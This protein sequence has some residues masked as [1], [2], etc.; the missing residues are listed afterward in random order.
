M[1]VDPA[2]PAL[3]V[4]IPTFNNEPVLQKTIASWRERAAGENVEILVIEDGCRDG[5]RDFLEAQCRTRWGAR[6]LRWLH[7][8]DAHELRCTN[9]GIAAARSPLVLAWQ[10]DMFLR[11]RWLVPELLRTFDAYPDIGLLSLSRG[12]DHHPAAGPIRSWDDLVDWQRLTSTIG[13]P[14]LNWFRIQEVDGVIRPGVVRRAC[15]D[16]VGALDEA[17]V[18]TEWDESDLACRIRQAGWKVAT[19]GYERLGGYDHLGSST[20]GALCDAYKARVL[21]NGLLFHERW[22]DAIARD[23]GRRRAVWRRRA[24][25]GGWVGTAGRML[26]AAAS[27][28]VG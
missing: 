23:H 25:P 28:V 26:A 8:D 19:C 5:T 13:P 6:H 11:R 3:S 22:D 1:P 18:P 9:A 4:V 12:V 21:R 20:L 27:R 16:R 15:I 17:F 14:P 7:M 10:D 2:A 24:T